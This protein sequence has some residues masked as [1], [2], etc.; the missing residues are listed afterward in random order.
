MNYGS[1]DSEAKS[2]V[3]GTAA[4]PAVTSM[5][6]QGAPLLS[7]LS[8]EAANAPFG[9]YMGRKIT[10]FMPVGRFGMHP[11]TDKALQ[12][13]FSDQFSRSSAST[14]RRGNLSPEGYQGAVSSAGAEWAKTAFP[15]IQAY[16]QYLAQLAPSLYG[17]RLGFA[18]LPLQTGAN[19]MGSQ[20][21]SSGFGFGISAPVTA[22]TNI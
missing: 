19:L 3:R 11:Q 17:Q 10:D 22:T 6:S 12:G 14:A 21:Q 1:S 7:S 9:T 13:L 18:N 20:S 5:I 8:A 16:Q 4:E 15:Q 2:G